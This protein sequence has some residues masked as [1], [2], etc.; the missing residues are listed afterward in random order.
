MLYL[1]KIGNGQTKIFVDE[2]FKNFNHT[3]IDLFSI[4]HT[5]IHTIAEQI[6]NNK[7]IIYYADEPPLS[8]LDVL[9]DIFN[10]HSKKQFCILTD[11]P[12]WTGLADWPS[13]VQFIYYSFSLYSY[14]AR[15]SMGAYRN[16]ACC[17]LKEFDSEKIGIS[18]N[19]LPRMHRLGALS[20]MLGI[21]LDSVCEITAPLLKWFLDTRRITNIMDVVPWNFELHEGFKNCML[22][23]W[24]R[25]KT[26]DGIAVTGSDAYPPYN[27]FRPGGKVFTNAINYTQNLLPWYRK[28]FVEFITV[29]VFDYNLPWICEKMLNSQ[30]ASNFPIWIAGKGTVA[31]LRNNKF[32]V[33]DDVVNHS[34]DLESDPVLRIQ[35]AIQDNKL[36]LQNPDYTKELWLKHHKRFDDNV[37]WH[38]NK[39]DSTVINGRK[40]L[41]QW[42]ES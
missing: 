9:I 3:D 13:N 2:E 23:G 10:A 27:D 31:W 4:D 19:R 38:M 18:L 20:Y 36:L 11:I 39:S 30:L 32:D 34:Y 35:K 28:S 6:T 7:V 33:F 24:E 8:G 42:I 17:K 15:D 26:G 29:T 14:D 21:G 12:G 37:R 1:G 16:I 25:A 5:E 41:A 22:N 40:L